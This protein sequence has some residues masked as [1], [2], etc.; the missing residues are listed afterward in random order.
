MKA[1]DDHSYLILVQDDD[2][3]QDF[4]G[5]LE[6]SVRLVPEDT[7]PKPGLQAT[8]SMGKLKYLL[9]LSHP[10]KNTMEVNVTLMM[11]QKSWNR[12]VTVT[13]EVNGCQMSMFFYVPRLPVALWIH[14]L[15]VTQSPLRRPWRHGHGPDS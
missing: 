10:R 13:M 2:M 8:C 7:A 5:F 3:P 4:Y 1:G 9:W 15:Q 6:E 12:N 11:E 14:G